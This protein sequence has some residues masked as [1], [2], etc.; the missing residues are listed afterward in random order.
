MAIKPYLP[1]VLDSSKSNMDVSGNCK[2][3]IDQLEET[4][5][6]LSG[7]VDG[8]DA[9]LFRPREMLGDTEVRNALAE[10]VPCF[11]K[12]TS[13]NQEVAGLLKNKQRLAKTK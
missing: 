12:L 1:P 4:K 13:L 8:L 9:M 2:S 11:M 3:A 5:N 6:E 10:L 7:H